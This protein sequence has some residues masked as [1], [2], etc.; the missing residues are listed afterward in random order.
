MLDWIK[1]LEN[2]N[3]GSGKF[4]ESYQDR[5][6]DYIFSNVKPTNSPPYCIEFGYCSDSLINKSI[7][8]T[9]KLILE[10]G[11][12]SLLLDKGNENS[13]INLYKHLLTSKN[14]CNVFAKY[15]VPVEPEYIS[16]DI[17]SIDLW[18]FNSL[19][20]NYKAKLF[21]VE[22]NCN[23]PIH[24]SITLK[25]D[26]TIQWK[27]NSRAFGA[28]L[29]A[30]NT[31]AQN[32]GYVLLWVVEELDAFFIR[33]DLIDDKSNLISF[34]IEKWR[35]TT[36]IPAGNLVK[37]KK[38]LNNFIDYEVYLKT[39]GNFLQS[40]KAARQICQETFFFNLSRELKWIKRLPEKWRRNRK[41]LIEKFV[42]K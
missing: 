4:S 24:S 29:K 35:Y 20:Q 13:K 5:L 11:W 42:F 12:N 9:T 2:Q 10:K 23:F 6:L 25:N 38:E 17:D 32:N 16:I 8:N 37:Y 22:Y 34:P 21:S 31:V 33:K 15:N 1:N 27:K 40:M 39:D 18:I 26:P 36:N 41:R 19:I 30:L 14:I 7:A 28:S 3:F